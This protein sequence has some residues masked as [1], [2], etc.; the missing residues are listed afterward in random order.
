[1]VESYMVLTSRYCWKG[2]TR[3]QMLFKVEVLREIYIPYEVF[4][5]VEIRKVEYRKIKM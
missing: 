4:R 3:K 1:M 5:E 2:L